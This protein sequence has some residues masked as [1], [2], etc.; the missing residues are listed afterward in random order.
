VLTPATLEDARGMLWTAL[1]DPDPVLIFENVMLYN[2]TGVLDETAGAVDIAGAAVRREGTDVEPDHLWRVAVQ[3]AGS[4]RGTGREGITRR[5]SIC[6]PCA[7]STTQHHGVGRHKTR[8][9]VFVDEGWRT[10]SIS[11]EIGMQIMPNRR[12]FELDAPVE[13]V[14]SRRFRSP[15]PAHLEDASIPQVP[16]IVAAARKGAG[17]ALRWPNSSCPR[18]ARTWRPG[19]WS[20]G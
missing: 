16:G 12:F 8:R 3:D 18:S 7:R 5:S 9:A 19:S 10:G 1:Q 17:G 15:I 20:N 13:R 14:C 4:G 11:A 6:G 2:R